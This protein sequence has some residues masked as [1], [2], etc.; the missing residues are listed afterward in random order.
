MLK[1]RT[2]HHGDTEARRKIPKISVSP[3]LCGANSCGSGAFQADRCSSSALLG[4][5]LAKDQPGSMDFHSPWGSEASRCVRPP[6][7][8]PFPRFRG[9]GRRTFLPPIPQPLSL[10]IG[11]K[12]LGD[13]G[14]SDRCVRVAHPVL[15]WPGSASLK[16]SRFKSHRLYGVG[17]SKVPP[18]LSDF[19]AP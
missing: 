10:E 18:L 4:V 2:I 19:P 3:C 5:V 8:R 17:E 11:G 9:E 13:R 14:H 6:Y 15:Y 16:W 12:G 7:P 1:T